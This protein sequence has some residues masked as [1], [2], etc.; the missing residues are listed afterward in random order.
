MRYFSR[1]TKNNYQQTHDAFFVVITF[2]LKKVFIF[3]YHRS[4]CFFFFS[5]KNVFLLSLS[6]CA[7]QCVNDNETCGVLRYRSCPYPSV[8]LFLLKFVHD[9]PGGQSVGRVVIGPYIPRSSFTGSCFFR[10]SGVFG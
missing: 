10:H 3:L 7:S 2:F 8:G 1:K 6:V 5:K 4:W 9:S